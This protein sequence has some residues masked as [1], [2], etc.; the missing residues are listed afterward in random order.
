MVNESYKFLP[1]EHYEKSRKVFSNGVIKITCI[2]HDS[3]SPPGGDVDIR[4]YTANG[5][6]I[7]NLSFFGDEA[8]E[9][10]SDQG[11]TPEEIFEK[12]KNLG[13]LIKEISDLKNTIKQTKTSISNI[14]RSVSVLS[15]FD[16]LREHVNAIENMLPTALE[17]KQSDLKDKQKQLKS[18]QEELERKQ[19][20]K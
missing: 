18:K 17:P 6:W 8:F 20:Y 12:R 1:K 3:D 14:H 9:K 11:F 13:L 5:E 15:Q 19:T 4:Y 2:Y 7:E 16:M 10:L